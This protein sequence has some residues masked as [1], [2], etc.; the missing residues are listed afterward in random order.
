MKKIFR[1]ILIVV[2]ISLVAYSPAA[3]FSLY[4][5]FSS[6]YFA[7]SYTKMKVM[8]DSTHIET[9]IYSD[10]TTGSPIHHFYVLNSEIHLMVGSSDK[11]LIKRQDADLAL[12]IWNYMENHNDSIW[13]WYHPQA[14]PKYAKK[15]EDKYPVAGHIRSLVVNLSALIL[16]IYAIYWQTNNNRK[17]K[18]K[19]NLR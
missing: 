3:I 2:F 16:A 11:A 7:S 5:N 9:P 4:N 1:V 10:G 13:I 17:L 15:E 14:A 8:V 19:N 6:L 12:E 18:K